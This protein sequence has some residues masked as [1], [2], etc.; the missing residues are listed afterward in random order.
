M[1]HREGVFFDGNG[2]PVC[3]TAMP[4]CRCGCFSGIGRGAGRW[5]AELVVEV[6]LPGKAAFPCDGG[7][8]PVCGVEL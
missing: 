7:D 1:R 4:S 6:G 3:L 2:F 8:T 5:G